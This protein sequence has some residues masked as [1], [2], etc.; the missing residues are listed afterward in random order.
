[1][2][3]DK[4]VYQ[5]IIL[6][7][8]VVV[9][10][11]KQPTILPHDQ[12]LIDELPYEYEYTVKNSALQRIGI[13]VEC[14][15]NYTQ[16]SLYAD[17]EVILDNYNLPKEGLHHFEVLVDFKTTGKKKMKWVRT[18]GDCIIKK[19][20]Y[21]ENVDVKIPQFIDISDEVGL[22]TEPSWKYGGPTIAD[23]DNNGYY[24]LILNNHDKISTQLFLQKEKGKLTEQVLFPNL[25]DYHGTAAGDFDNDGDLDLVNSIGGGNGTNPKP[26]LF[27]KNDNG[28]FILSTE[29]VGIMEGAR[30]RS[31]RW[32]DMDLDGDLDLFSV[33][34]AG[35]NSTDS[36]Q[37]MIYENNGKGNFVRRRV[38]GLENVSAE[39]VLITDINNDQV[40]DLIMY[41]PLSIWIGNGDFTYSDVSEKWLPD[42]L[43]DIDLINAITDIDVDNNGSLD[44]YLARGK[45]HYEIANKSLDFDPIKGQID[46]RDE[47]NQ[48]VTTLELNAKDSI[49]ISD[50]FLWYRQYNGGF[51]LHLGA[52]K[53]TVTIQESESITLQAENAKGWPDKREEN[54][55]YIGY[56]GN[57]KWRMESVRKKAI[58]WGIRVSIAGV[59]SVNPIGWTP[60]NRNV[61]DLLLVNTGSKFLNKS[62]SSNI[63]LGGN[64]WGVTRGDFNN[65]SYQDLFVNRFGGLKSRVT[66]LLLLNDGKGKFEITS[67]HNA[68]DPLDEGHGDMG[69]AFD[70]DLDGNVDILSGSDDPGKWYLYGNNT[71]EDNY[72]LVRV[73][74]SH[75]GNIDPYSAVVTVKTHNNTYRQ[76][77]GS[78]GE[79]HSQSLLNS[80]HFGLGKVAKIKSIKVRWR[81]GEELSL[82]DL[83]A[84][85]LYDFPKKN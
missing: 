34:A 19:V 56:L 10:C 35:I 4:S 9:S 81:N 68:K 43:V 72:L 3:I 57:G 65:D 74:Y 64:N 77:V 8:L 23:I 61:P 30:G 13:W 45:T 53:D 16:L 79:I 62:N 42:D 18:G 60:Q 47:G 37:H 41:T 54:G 75:K 2:N 1:M 32:I 84:N 80:V 31:V 33:N 67:S 14:L 51:P 59:N 20:L 6:L 49:T 12:M 82:K 27:M 21:H 38:A 15:E 50:I 36:V 55:W 11:S 73:G 70:F 44:L 63:P 76:R 52:N 17:G 71:K 46:I 5:L 7:I 25:A 69:Q 48:G 28:K 22:I 26:P 58:Y 78:A 66:D 40:D 24:D 39:R 29:R 83:K 85:Q